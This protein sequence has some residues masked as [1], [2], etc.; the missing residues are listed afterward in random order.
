MPVVPI[1]ML[2]PALSLTVEQFHRLIAT[3]HLKTAPHLSTLRMQSRYLNAGPTKA[4]LPNRFPYALL[5]PDFE[6]PQAT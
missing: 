6:T 4:N 5:N 1:F 3:E 2:S